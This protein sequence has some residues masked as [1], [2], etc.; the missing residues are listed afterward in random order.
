MLL[1][2]LDTAN[3]SLVAYPTHRTEQQRRFTSAL[4]A[5][6]DGGRPRPASRLRDLPGSVSAARR[7]RS[8]SVDAPMPLRLFDPAL[9]HSSADAI[10]QFGQAVITST[11]LDRNFTQTI[12]GQLRQ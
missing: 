7:A 6:I 3:P 2:D 11:P 9:P 4:Q 10:A 8:A 1:T 5:R 12:S